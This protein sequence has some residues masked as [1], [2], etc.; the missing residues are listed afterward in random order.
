MIKSLPA[1]FLFSISLVFATEGL[2]Y[3]LAAKQIATDTYVFIGAKEDFSHDNG[4]NIVNTGFIVTEQG[5]VVIDTGPSYRYGQ[6]MRE[7]IARITDKA[8]IKVLITHHHPDHFLGNQAYKDVPIY[9]LARTINQLKSD[10]SGFLDN[11]Y[12]MVGPW[13]S[14][15]EVS[16]SKIK[17]LSLMHEQ[18][19]NH[20]LKYIQ[21]GGHTASDLMILDETTGVLFAGDLVF[22]NR[23]LTTPHAEPELWLESLQLIKEIDFKTIVPGH[24]ETASDIG[25]IEQTRD[26]LVW[27]E[28]TIREAVNQGMEMNEVLAL[29]IPE[30]FSGF[31]VLKREFARSVSHRYPVYETMMFNV[32]N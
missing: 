11:V 6:Q 9:A 22:H 10:A 29:P 23:T 3:K 30:R 1:L 4:G 18:V 20:A 32:T 28:T 14:G 7:A 24:G 16:I 13:M 21:L 17:P 27:L 8:I 31:G 12:R 2:D 15:T 19:A 26:Y 25:P 5:V